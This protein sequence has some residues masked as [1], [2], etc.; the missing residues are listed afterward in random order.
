MYLLINEDNSVNFADNHP[1]RSGLIHEG[2][3]LVEILDKTL[4]EVV[5]EIHPGEAYWDEETQQVIRNPILL[6]K[7]E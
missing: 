1:I 3:T 6:P 7:E 2:T 4:A 5:G